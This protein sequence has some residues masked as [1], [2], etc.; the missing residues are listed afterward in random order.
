MVQKL[1]VKIK[2]RIFSTPSATIQAVLEELRL[3][4]SEIMLLLPQEN[5]RE[6]A[7][8]DRIRR[9]YQKALKKYPPAAS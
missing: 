3:L 1:Q 9:S 4:R 7:H 5:L 8:S 6:Y 2:S